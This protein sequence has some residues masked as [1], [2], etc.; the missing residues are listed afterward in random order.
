[1]PK[2]KNNKEY[3]YFTVYKLNNKEIEFGRVKIS[4]SNG[5]PSDAAR[6][7]LTSICDYKGLTKQNRVK[8]NTTYYIRETTSDRVKRVYGPYKG[9]FKKYDKPFIVELKDGRKIKHTMYPYVIKVKDKKAKLTKSQKGGASIVKQISIQNY[10]NYDN[11]GNLTN[12]RVKQNHTDTIRCLVDIGGGFI[13][14]GSDD[15]TIKTWNMAAGL[16]YKKRLVDIFMCKPSVNNSNSNNNSLNMVFSM[17]L[18]SDNRIVASTDQEKLLFFKINSNGQI[19]KIQLERTISVGNNSNNNLNIFCIIQLR[20][21]RLVTGD[22]VGNIKIMN[23]NGTNNRPLLEGH[24][25]PVSGMMPLQGGNINGSNNTLL[26]KGHTGAVNSIIQLQDG[27]IVSCSDDKSLKIWDIK[28]Q[29]CIQTLVRHNSEISNVIQLSDGTIVSGDDDGKIFFWNILS[30]PNGNPTYKLTNI[31]QKNNYSVLCMFQKMNSNY[32]ILT[33]TN[34]TMILFDLSKGTAERFIKTGYT[35][36]EIVEGKPDITY[37]A[38]SAIELEDGRIVT[39]GVNG[40]MD[41]WTIQ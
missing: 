2:S 9:T 7:L 41:V 5:R 30:T 10:D 3:R 19:P 25:N 22:E 33:R 21:G 12:N 17:T 32:M 14:S 8:C 38:Y 1:M 26:L 31:Y 23:I 15:G 37:G 24:T 34:D 20:D 36:T 29:K 40:V 13:I 6:K 39:G 4:A 35:K 27:N 28:E 16:N 11:Y 18:L